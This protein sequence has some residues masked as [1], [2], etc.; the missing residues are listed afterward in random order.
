M[1][2]ASA[3]SQTDQLIGRE[4]GSK[5]LCLAVVPAGGFVPGPAPASFPLYWLAADAGG[6]GPAD[7][8]DGQSDLL[9]ALREILVDPLMDQLWIALPEGRSDWTARWL[10]QGF[11]FW[12]E[13]QFLPGVTDNLAHTVQEAFSLKRLPDQIKVAS[14]SGFLFASS[15]NDLDSI[16][17]YSRYRFYHPLTDRFE[18]HDLSAVHGSCQTFLTFPAVHLPEPRKAEAIPLDGDDA[19]LEALSRERLLALNL[20]EMKA[21]KRYYAKDGL[22]ELRAARDLPPWPT[23]VE[24]EIIAQTWSEHC[25]HKIFNATI[26][27]ADRSM[28]KPEQ[29][30]V[31]DS[32]YKSYIQA[33]TRELQT[34][35]KDL[36]SVFEDNAGVVRWNQD[37]GICFKV[38]TH[39]SPSALEPYGGALTGILG[40]NR[41]ILG[42]GLGARPIFNTDVFC[43][44]YPE[45]NLP[46][47]PKLLP[48]KAILDGVR[49]GVED[50]GNK[51]GIPTVNGAIYF[52]RDY[53]A[54]PLVFCGT[55]GMLPL[56][57][58]GKP[59]FEKHTAAGDSIVM[60][61]GR[62]GVDGVHGATFSSEALHEGSPVSAVQI[63]DPFTQKRMLDFVI[64][65]RDAGLVTGI[66]D[67]GAGGLS[68]SVG[69]MAR[70]TGGASIEL[71]RIP[72][73][74]PGLADW[75]I[76]ISESQERMTLSTRDFGE[77]SRLAEKHNVEVTEIGTFHDLGFF[78]VTRSGKCVALL[79]LEFLHEGVPK[80]RLQSEW[81]PP[82][83]KAEIGAP[84]ESLTDTLLSLIAHPNICSREP[85]IRQYDHEVQ[86]MSVI[87]PL[88]GEQQQGPCD[89]AV[90]RPLYG[91]DAGLVI[92][93]GICPRLSRFDTHLMA[94][95]AVD[96]A[97]RNAICVGADP[98]T[99]AI[100]DNFCWPDPVESERNSQGRHKLA[101]LVRA[102]RGLFE[103]AVAYGVPLI[104]GKDSMKNDFDDGVVRLSI[105]P[106]LLVSAL[107]KMPSIY[108]AVTME[109]KSDGDLIYLLSAGQ[110]GL[111]GSHYEEMQGWSSDCLPSINLSLAIQM[112]R[113]LY[114]SMQQSL[115]K[116]CH[117]LSEGGLAV[118]LAECVIGSGLGAELRLNDV[119]PANDPLA[120]R[121]AGPARTDPAS[122]SIGR[123]ADIRL[124]AE[125]PA[126]IIVSIDPS[127]RERWE[128]LWRG[129]SCQLVGVVHESQRLSVL[130]GAGKQILDA[131]A[132]SLA[133]AWKTPLP[134]D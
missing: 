119:P 114:E 45:P 41:D 47:R 29:E 18:I 93:N 122:S 107:G 103:A 52:H 6:S 75:E 105:P 54:K 1:S 14:G 59:G 77:L 27:H 28:P 91:E 51:S 17:H 90:L 57:V 132:A 123:R 89:A 31:I 96:E 63:G 72:L 3:S 100:L 53:R 44:A 85:I 99:L 116:S 26:S 4:G 38:E 82:V 24:L 112:Y 133:E 43:F 33:A 13:R 37:W 11:R 127:D 81:T 5:V 34:K 118:G 32:L 117:D 87:K 69:E 58:H 70:L 80:L 97:V 64:E 49:K 109:F 46:E 50:G 125:G 39:N 73:K 21:I 60:A 23:D 10:G 92:S 7:I 61:G 36:L 83:L 66:T 104:S 48:A 22:A 40:V 20:D 35:R 88:M 134:F 120:D 95:C 67:N 79:E 129:F 65:A 106:T 19:A 16:E 101:Q 9:L 2:R 84:P 86:G 130:D 12:A 108:R 15:H 121:K 8:E 111:A 68:S 74:Y 115:V 94:L 71:D 62:V 76:V 55:G 110:A 30:Q 42:T 98:D 131:H 78:Q 25:K 124:F 56:T 113:Q 102:C 128:S 126:R